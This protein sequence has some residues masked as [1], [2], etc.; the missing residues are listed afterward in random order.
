MNAGTD[1]WKRGGN[2][3][4]C[5]RAKYCKKQC[6]EHKRF[7]QYVIQQRI[8]NSQAGKMMDAIHRMTEEI[9]NG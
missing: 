9:P 3:N 6:S 4:N 7:M 2:C 5:R 1:Q 8:L